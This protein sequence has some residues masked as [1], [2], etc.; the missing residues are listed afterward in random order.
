M[1]I[2]DPTDDE[3][4]VVQFSEPKRGTYK[5]LI[6]RKGRL[7]GAIM[8]GDLGKVAYLMQAFDKNSPLPDDRLSLLFD[9]GAPSQKVTLAEMPEDAQV[10]NCNGVSKAAI[11]QCVKLGKR[12]AKSVMVATRAGMGCGSCKG[13]VG[14]LVEWFCGGEVD[15]DPTLHYYVPTIP[16]NKEELIK[17]VREKRLRSVSSVFAELGG[18]HEDASS[19]PALA[20]LL[21]IVWKGDYEDERDARFINDRVHG[22]IQKDGTFSVIPEM[23]GGVCTSRG[24]SPDCRRGR[25][26]SSA[27]HEAHRRAADRPGGNRQGR[28]SRRMAGPRHAG[29]FGVGQELS[30]VQ[31]LYRHRVL[32]LRARR[33]HGAGGKDREEVSRTRQPWKAQTGDCRLP[34]QLLR[35]PRQGRGRGRD[36]GRKVGDLR[37]RR[38][39]L[40]HSQ[41]ATS[42][43][44]STI[45]TQ[46]LLL[47][48]RFIQYYRENAKY[49][50]R[51]YVFV[52]RIGIARVKAIVVDDS[53]GIAADLDRA[54][55]ESVDATY[56]PWL[57]RDAPVT[58]NQ[59]VLSLPVV[60]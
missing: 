21:S 43:A 33:Q 6:I 19:K 1:G 7:A 52:E 57:E 58:T 12:T 22:N 17:A 35:G 56:D 44:R 54:L 36:R 14:D 51:T 27:A 46:V 60:G 59:F 38:G 24:A 20:S 40:A 48:G 47:S 10:C 3:D 2:T 55:Q 31:E 30:D 23:P 53:D 50:E 28:P 32:S 34:A 37:R 25:Q 26:V 8:V 9:I 39:R 4:E 18:G 41:R 29:R 15:E 45:T 11:G 42:S 13:L 5:K 16:L 49:K